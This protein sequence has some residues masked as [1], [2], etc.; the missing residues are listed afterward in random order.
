MRH[1]FTNVLL[2]ETRLPSGYVTSL[3]NCAASH[4]DT[5][6]GEAIKGG[7]VAVA[8]VAGLVVGGGRPGVAVKTAWVEPAPCV[9]ADAV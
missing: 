2:R 5:G 3:M 8:A 6:T 1:I 9:R 7:F 4:L